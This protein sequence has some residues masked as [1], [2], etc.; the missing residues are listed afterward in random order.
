MWIIISSGF[1]CCLVTYGG[2]GHSCLH[3]ECIK[4]Q[5]SI[6]F[7]RMD[8]IFVVP[9]IGQVRWTIIPGC[10]HIRKWLGW[11]IE[12]IVGETQHLALVVKM[13]I[14]KSSQCE[15]IVGARRRIIARVEYVALVICR[16]AQF[17]IKSRCAEIGNYTCIKSIGE[18]ILEKSIHT[19][20]TISEVCA[21]F[22]DFLVIAECVGAVNVINAPVITPTGIDR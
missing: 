11:L 5:C 12:P 7:D 22:R 10:S 14:N 3:L 18:F 9:F 4:W 21:T 20:R 19:K 1:Q 2:I 15:C 17:A 6:K 13:P 16:I 8:V